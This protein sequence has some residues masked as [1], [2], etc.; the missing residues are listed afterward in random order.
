M[1]TTAIVCPRLTSLESPQ[2]HQFN[3]RR[4]VILQR[5]LGMSALR[6]IFAAIATQLPSLRQYHHKISLV[7]LKD[8]VTL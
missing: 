5:R 4:A 6:Q 7:A 8:R 3:D 1:G 2:C